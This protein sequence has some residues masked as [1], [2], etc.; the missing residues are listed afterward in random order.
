MTEQISRLP[1]QEFG[2][3]SIPAVPYILNLTEPIGTILRLGLRS[4]QVQPAK[5]ALSNTYTIGGRT[6]TGYDFLY[7]STTSNPL[8]SAFS[9]LERVIAAGVPALIKRMTASSASLPAAVTASQSSS[10]PLEKPEQFAISWTNYWD[11]YKNAQPDLAP[12]A[13]SLTSVQA[14]AEQFWPN[15]AAYGSAYNLIILKL[16]DTAQ[17]VALKPQFGNVWTGA[18]LDAIQAD[19]RLY[20][21]DM[22]IFTSFA[23]ATGY[24]PVRFTPGTITLLV[25][26]ASTKKLTPVAIMVSGQSSSVVYSAGTSNSGA[27]LYALQAAKASITVWGIWIGHV[28][29]YHIVTAAMQMTM[30]NNIPTDH[31]IY[32]L[33]E[34]RSNYLIGFNEVLLILWSSIAPPTSFDNPFKFLSLM[35]KYATGRSYFDDDPM[36]TLKAM[37]LDPTK[38]TQSQA[39]DLY[40][41]VQDLLQLWQATSDYVNVFV[42]TTYANDAAIVADAPLQAWMSASA[43][44]AQGN[45]RGLPAMTNKQA[46][47]DVLT[48]L[49]YRVTAHGIARLNNTANPPLTFAS[50]Y[51]PCLQN[52]TLPPNDQPL[53]T[54]SLLKMLPWTETI[55]ELVNFYFIFVFSVPYESFIPPGGVDS[56]LPFPNGMIDPRNRAI[57]VY[58]NRLIEFINGYE[59]ENPQLSQWP[60]NIET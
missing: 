14:A 12:W 19:G 45:I 20:V 35:D 16:V 50:N 25:Q 18:G 49:L 7:G 42:E 34:P 10:L 46:L 4:L 53:D 21:I 56:N 29:H 30:Y 8:S 38:F 58:R 33:I 52:T 26:D 15:I 37:G 5:K 57:V 27:W 39:W 59:P 55:G 51:P 44:P 54:T 28:Y 22:S 36:P 41:I 47:K 24:N 2:F 17:A 13:S 6:A 60:L 40:P 9:E 31:P 3:N 11:V 23:P 43:D 1:L 48:S 32:Q